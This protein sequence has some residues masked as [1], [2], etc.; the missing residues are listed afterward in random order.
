MFTL[1]RRDLLKQAGLVSVGFSGLQTL[2]SRLEATDVARDDV[3][4]GLGPLAR[5]PRGV[6]DLPDGFDY[7]VFSKTG[8][9]MDDG[10]YV[11][12]LHDGMAAFPGP[13]RTTILVRNHEIG[14]ALPRYGAFGW[15]NELLDRLDGS[16]L[17]DYGYGRTPRLGG[18]TTLVYDT[19]RRRLVRHSLSLAGTSTNCAGGPTPWG[20]WIT[21]EETEA[22]IDHAHEADHGYAFEVPASADP[23]LHRATPIRPMGRFKREAVAVDPTTG[24]VYQTEDQHDSLLYRYVPKAPGRL[25]DGGRTQ[26]LAIL[27]HPSCDTRA[28]SEHDPRPMHVGDVVRTAWIDLEDID[29]PQNDLRR[30][31]FDAGAARFARGEGIWFGAGSVFF[32]C[33]NGGSA[34]HGQ[35]FRYMPA[36]NEGTP[37]EAANPGALELFQESARDDML[38]N[39]DNLTMAPWGDLIICE[40]GSGA[41]RIVGITPGGTMYHIAANQLNNSEMA[42]V[43][44]SPD[45]S[46]LFVNVQDPGLTMA[47]TGPWERAR[48]N[49]PRFDD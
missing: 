7:H 20:T 46:T 9:R 16:D 18:T 41:D 34:K 10:F 30:R 17:Y 2:V 8:E 38:R 43:T 32:A 47:I 19:D 12:A 44:F 31:G 23:R 13:N 26:A 37:E 5:D 24:I 40:D 49:E 42:G 33:T 48:T 6:L 28:W 15:N 4:A 22:R 39:A 45:G 29:A 36:A 27:D 3:A 14:G 1:S 35:V 21:C 11:P 25:M